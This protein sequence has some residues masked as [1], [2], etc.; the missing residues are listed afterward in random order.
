MNSLFPLLAFVII[1]FVVGCK[2]KSN[3]ENIIIPKNSVFS[4][5][6][7]SPSNQENILKNYPRDSI[8][9]LK[10]NEIKDS[11]IVI[12][13]PF[14]VIQNKVKAFYVDFI[15]WPSKKVI[16]TIDVFKE[17]PFVKEGYEVIPKSLPHEFF[18]ISIPGNG[19]KKEVK[20]L[21][22]KEVYDLIPENIQFK[23]AYCKF[24]I[25][26]KSNRFAVIAYK[27]DLDIGYDE[28]NGPGFGATRIFIFD[29][30]G[31][32]ID[33]IVLN[34]L[35]ISN[36]SISVDGKYLAFFY[37]RKPYEMAPNE[38]EFNILRIRDHK[39]IYKESF[40]NMSLDNVWVGLNLKNNV[41]IATTSDWPGGQILCFDATKHILYISEVFT[42]RFWLWT[43][44]RDYLYV[45]FDQKPPRRLYFDKDFKIIPL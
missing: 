24:A 35:L 19:Y 43:N 30:L 11:L 9:F 27:I 12:R 3:S 22:T 40:N 33:Q 26:V 6:I 14:E 39:V 2:Y 8:V 21:F 34:G 44:S 25:D 45:E 5:K 38:F 28:R 20:K 41:I 17:N 31:E 7:D 23:E 37:S 4:E 1:W 18:M 42:E 10:D 36:P 32:K 29:S 15:Q 13:R 16:K